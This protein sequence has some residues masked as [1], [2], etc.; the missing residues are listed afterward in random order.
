LAYLVL[1]PSHWQLPAWFWPGSKHWKSRGWGYYWPAVTADLVD[2]EDIPQ[3]L[4]EVEVWA[5]FFAD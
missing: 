3:A 1:I 2:K 4:T 5:S